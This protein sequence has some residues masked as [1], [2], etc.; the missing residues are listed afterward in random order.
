MSETKILLLTNRDSDNI[1]DQLIEESVI[2][3]LHGIM[4]N[5]G[6]A[7][8]EYSINSRAAGIITKKYLQT[9]EPALLEGAR[10]AISSADIIVFGGAP[11]FNYSYQVFYKRTIKTLELAQEYGVPVLFSSIGV[12]KFDANSPKVQELQEALR[13]SCVKQVT[14]RDDYESLT[15]YMHGVNAP[16]GRVSDPVVLARHVF[17]NKPKP[18]STGKKR[19][20]LVVTRSGIFA[21]N[22]IE[23]TEPQQREFWLE[24]VKLLKARGYDYRLFTTG[25][26]ADEVFLDSLLRSTDLPA[27]NVRVN[28]N[29]PEELISEI[30]ACSGVI[31]YRL[32]ANISSFAYGVPAIGL[33]WNSKVPLFYDSIGYPE[34][35]LGREQ[36]TAQ[37]VVDALEN[38]MSQGVEPDEQFLMS[39]YTSL[40][41]GI[42]EVVDP[43]SPIAPYTYGELEH[44]L[45]VYTGTSLELYREKVNKKLRRTYE[46]Y[47]ALSTQFKTQEQVPLSV[48][49]KRAL[50]LPARI[51]K[52]LV[53]K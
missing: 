11:L 45:P 31:A 52:R 5:L 14:T 25:H 39:V 21:A 10:T 3:I 41:E 26:F 43:G 15:Q 46:S 47:Q 27:N 49:I 40:F 17:G 30:S 12:E 20:G 37:T 24:T 9:G 19:I 48:E 32:H 50:R 35:A 29:T 7:Q 28:V 18:N 2:S 53:G 36:W 33:T 44:K 23:F 42:K 1:G 8:D 16:I 34:R 13:L 4:T 22:G 6:F 38:A 51:A